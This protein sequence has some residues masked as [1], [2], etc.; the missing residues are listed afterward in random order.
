MSAWRFSWTCSPAERWDLDRARALDAALEAEG[1]ELAGSFG[2]VDF[3]TLTADNSVTIDG[4]TS[5]R[6]AH[7]TRIIAETVG[8]TVTARPEEN[9]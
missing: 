6:A 4:I 9:P 1:V 8:H 2:G 3:T 5:E 7:L